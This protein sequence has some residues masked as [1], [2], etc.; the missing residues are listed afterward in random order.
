MKIKWNQ[1]AS[2]RLTRNP[3]LPA[4]DC[5][6]TLGEALTLEG[7]TRTCCPSDPP[8]LF[9]LVFSSGDPPFQAPFHLQ[10]SHFYFLKKISSTN[11]SQFWLNFCSWHTNFS[12]NLFLRPQFQV[13]KS[14]PETQLLTWGGT[15]LPKN[16]QVP[17]K[18]HT[19]CN[20]LMAQVHSIFFAIQTIDKIKHCGALLINHHNH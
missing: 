5:I 13:K 15:Y 2:A 12:K 18:V 1:D 10:R 16:F 4:L 11:L 8:P 7:S 19:S 14:V 3:W 9:R 6:H 20:L 17:P